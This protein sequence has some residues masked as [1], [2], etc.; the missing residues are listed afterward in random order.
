VDATL[1]VL[2]QP[3]SQDALINYSFDWHLEGIPVLMD[4]RKSPTSRIYSVTQVPTTFLI[5][6]EGMV[7]QRWD[8]F[9]PAQDLAFALQELVGEPVYRELTE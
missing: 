2:G 1:L 3:T 7:K 9:A 4:G 8:G 5:D 6:G